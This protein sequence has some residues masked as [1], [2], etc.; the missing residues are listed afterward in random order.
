MRGTGTRFPVTLSGLFYDLDLVSCTGLTSVVQLGER[1][2]LKYLVGEHVPLGKP[3]GVNAHVKIPALVTE[4]VA[5]ADATNNPP[6]SARATRPLSTVTEPELDGTPTL[7][8][9]G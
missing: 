1:A 6:V 2:G 3:G 5:E 7:L 9:Q 8:H 4:T